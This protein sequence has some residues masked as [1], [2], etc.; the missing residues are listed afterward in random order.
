MDPADLATLTK[1]ARRR[2]I[3]WFRLSRLLD[4]AAAADMLAWER[5]GF[6]SMRA[7]G[8]HASN[9]KYR[10][11]EKSLMASKSRPVSRGRSFRA[12]TT[13]SLVLVTI[14][15]R[16]FNFLPGAISEAT[17]EYGGSCSPESSTY[18]KA[19]SETIWGG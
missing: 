18:K 8:S 7:S 13:G 14:R 1:Q 3:R 11:F 4:V 10:A 15:N 5:I 17:C 19:A 2:V 12:S 6:R 16:V 9:T